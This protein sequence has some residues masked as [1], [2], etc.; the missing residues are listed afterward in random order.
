MIQSVDW[1]HSSVISAWL[2]VFDSLQPLPYV[3]HEIY[4]FKSFHQIAQVELLHRNFYFF[5]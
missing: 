3:F 4:I 5:F 2:D 1:S